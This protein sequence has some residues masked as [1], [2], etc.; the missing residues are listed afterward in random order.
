MKN[1]FLAPW[2]NTALKMANDSPQVIAARLSRMGVPSADN[3]MECARMVTE[4]QQAMAESY[5]NWLSDVNGYWFN[6]WMSMSKAAFVPLDAK[7]AE[8]SLN[9]LIKPYQ[10]RASANARRLRSRR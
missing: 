4:K 10:R 2:Q 9:R 3:A 1:P 8:R 7:Q 6:A 5:F